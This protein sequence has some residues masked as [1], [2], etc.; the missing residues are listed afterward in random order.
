MPPIN[1]YRVHLNSNGIVPLALGNISAMV[2]HHKPEL[3]EHLNFETHFITDRKMADDETF[4]GGLTRPSLFLMS[5]YV[6]NIQAHA[7]LSQKLKRVNKDH[8]IIHGGPG[9]PYTSNEFLKNHEEV[10]FTVHGEGEATALDLLS[11]IVTEKDYQKVQGISYRMDGETVFTEKR[12]RITDLSIIPSPYLGGDLDT[13]FP[14]NY[15]AVVETNRGCPYKCAYCSWGFYLRRIIKHDL[16]Q[17]FEE[18]EWISRRKIPSLWLADANFG[19]LERD[20]EIA[21]HL[22]R[23]KERYGFPKNVITNFANNK[24]RSMEISRLLIGAKIATSLGV[25]M[26]TTDQTTLKNIHRKPVESDY[27]LTLRNEYVKHQLPVMTHFIIGLPGSTY[28]S[29]KKDIEFALEEK[30]YPQVFPAIVLP[31]TRMNEQAYR[32]M[33]GIVTE[34]FYSGDYG[35]MWE[36]IVSTSSF[37]REEYRKIHLLC[38]F[39]HFG[40]CYRTLKYLIYLVATEMGVGQTDILEYLLEIGKSENEKEGNAVRF[41]IL[42]DI[43]KTLSEKTE[44]FFDK[45]ICVVLR[46]NPRDLYLKLD[47]S[48][49]WPSFYQEMKN[50]L[51]E[52]FDIK[53]ELIDTTIGVQQGILPSS[54][55]ILQEITLSYDF[56]TYYF[57]DRKNGPLQSLNHFKRPFSFRV[58]DPKGICQNISLIETGMQ[59]LLNNFELDSPLWRNE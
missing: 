30:M 19:I 22:C 8:L 17:V 34:Q 35:E 29:F 23:M 56:K 38:S 54:G 47:A 7:K 57:Q 15:C 45:K 5:D 48:D 31:N 27:Y 44:E 50:A 28:Q 53:E 11:Q 36:V 6:W 32:E 24:R 1:V 42:R 40:V 4:I 43:A 13:L 26:Q 14:E 2:R 39:I 33:H 21:E 18:L 49:S 37:S 12:E 10:D 59:M 25:A 16:D 9:I 51:K 55:N 58:K 20:I 46:R 41:P 3:L 52:R